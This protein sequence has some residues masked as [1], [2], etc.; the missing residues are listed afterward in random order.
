MNVRDESISEKYIM[1][2]ERVPTEKLIFGSKA[3]KGD[4]SW[5]I[6]SEDSLG[7]KPSAGLAGSGF[8]WD[9]SH[10]LT[11]ILRKSRAWV[12]LLPLQMLVSLVWRSFFFRSADSQETNYNKLAKRICYLKL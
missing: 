4:V 7:T 10:V 6:L 12:G 3:S 11:S 1:I 8:V 5:L 2:C 9:N